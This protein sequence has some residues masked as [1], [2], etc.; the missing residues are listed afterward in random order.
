[1]RVKSA[2]GVAFG[3]L[4][5]PGCALFQ[6]AREAR[7]AAPERGAAYADVDLQPASVALSRTATGK[8]VG[9]AP[10]KRK[11]F[12]AQDCWRRGDQHVLYPQTP[13]GGVSSG[14][15]AIPVSESLLTQDGAIH[16]YTQD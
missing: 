2:L 7:Y 13:P 12:P 11:A 1:M 5:L 16:P 14:S 15:Q 6:P 9:L 10:C 4:L 3:L 8:P